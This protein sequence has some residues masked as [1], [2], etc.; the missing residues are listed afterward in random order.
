MEVYYTTSVYNSWL[1]LKTLPEP[2][3]WPPGSRDLIS[4][5]CRFVN[6]A[7]CWVVV[8]SSRTLLI[9]QFVARISSFNKYCKQYHLRHAVPNK[10]SLYTSIAQYLPCLVRPPTSRICVLG[11]LLLKSTQTWRP[12]QCFRQIVSRRFLCNPKFTW[13]MIQ[14]KIYYLSP[15]W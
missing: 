12:K 9:R 6:I 4:N 14:N 5:P 11:F 10:H 15:S 13:D 8:C 3:D 7:L 2:S 1:F